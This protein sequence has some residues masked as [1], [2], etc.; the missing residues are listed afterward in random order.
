MNMVDTVQSSQAIPL[1]IIY[2]DNT[3]YNQPNCP[4]TAIFRR[5][6]FCVPFIQNKVGDLRE[7]VKKQLTQL[8]EFVE[9]KNS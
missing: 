7:H 4:R 9:V 6:F 5:R 8:Q 2:H 1:T 3:I